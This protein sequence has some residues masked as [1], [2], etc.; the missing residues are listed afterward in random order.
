[1]LLTFRTMR[2][3]RNGQ[4][5]FEEIG[6]KPFIQSTEEL[7]VGYLKDKL[8]EL[9]AGQARK[10]LNDKRHIILWTPPYN[11]EL[12]PIE[13]FWVSKNHAALN[14]SCDITMKDT[15]RHL[16]EGWYGHRF[17]LVD[18]SNYDIIEKQPVDC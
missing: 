3:D 9:L 16:R 11:P 2:M 14:A 17:P 18:D 12:Q 1:M 10:A 7:I 15:V 4:R 5:T 13:L 6:S 8:P